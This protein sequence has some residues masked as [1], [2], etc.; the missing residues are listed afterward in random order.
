MHFVPTISIFL[1]A[2]PALVFM[3]KLP[4]ITTASPVGLPLPL[5]HSVSS[6]NTS[7]NNVPPIYCQGP[8][9]GANLQ[10]ASCLNAL[11]YLPSVSGTETISFGNRGSGTWDINVPDRYLSCMSLKS[12]AIHEVH[13]YPLSD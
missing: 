11:F 12:D 8:K 13:K 9:R 3:L 1:L 5:N 2:F 6:L 7:A 10:L 4:L